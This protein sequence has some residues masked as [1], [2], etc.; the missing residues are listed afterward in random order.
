MAGDLYTKRRRLI[1]TLSVLVL[2]S[3]P[4][5]FFCFD[6][7]GECIRLFGAE[8]GLA[9]MFYPLFGIVALLLL[10][11]GMGMK[12]GRLFC[13]HLCP[14]HLFLEKVNRP[15]NGSASH[16]KGIVW[17]WSLLFS[18]MLTEVILS[19]FQPL[20]NQ[21]KLAASGNLPI[22][23]TGVALFGGFMF[24]FVGYQERFCKKGCPYA[25]IQMLLQ[26]DLTRTMKFANREKT[27]TNCRKCE[28]ICPMNLRARFESKGPDCTNCNL[29][30]EA[31]TTEL[32][33][34]NTLFHFHDPE[35]ETAVQ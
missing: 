11:V 16:R 4:F 26:S 10:V 17:L 9:T 8:F 21:I 28:D 7:D 22:L 6:L 13:S 29:C 33:K 23:G 15:K 20:E 30:A 14:M 25:L 1:Q 32:G 3:I 18:V 35:P 24:L 12:K 19:F 27:C 34:G 5:R 31:C 2:L